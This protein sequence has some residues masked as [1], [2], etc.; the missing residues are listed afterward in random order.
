MP[1][2]NPQRG[3]IYW[4]DVP[5]RHTVGSEQYKR[6][7]W[8]VVSTNAIGYLPIVIGVPL[9]FEV[10]KKN[11]TFRIAILATD[12]ILE[13][14]A[15]LDPGELVALTEQVRV[16]STERMEFPRQGRITETALYA[17]EAG[18]AYVLDIQ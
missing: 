2:P 3:E 9:S 6:R 12:I 10:Q 15:T 18:L 1:N 14:G 5:R 17:V 16:L 13:P 7:P 11:R 8:L 4:I